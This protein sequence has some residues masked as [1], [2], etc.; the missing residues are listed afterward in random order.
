MS[1]IKIKKETSKYIDSE[2]LRNRNELYPGEIFLVTDSKSK[3]LNLVI[4][5]RR[6][7]YLHIYHEAVATITS[8]VV[9]CALKSIKQTHKPIVL[10][11]FGTCELTK[12]VG[13]LVKIRDSPYQNTELT[14]TNYREKK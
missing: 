12:K 1:I 14:L 11:W 5:G 9:D 10:L 3:Y 4:P 6:K 8:N 2:V 7:A 13:N